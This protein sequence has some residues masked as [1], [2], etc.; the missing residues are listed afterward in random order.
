LGAG[1]PTRSFPAKSA[2]LAVAFVVLI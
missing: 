1:E 2:A